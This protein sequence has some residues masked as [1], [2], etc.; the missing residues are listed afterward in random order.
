[1]TQITELWC[2]RCLQMLPIGNFRKRPRR[3]ETG[4]R[5]GRWSYCRQCEIN[6]VKTVPGRRE[7]ANSNTYAS[8]RRLKENNPEEYRRRY[9]KSHLRK[10]HGITIADYDRLFKEQNGHCAICE[11]PP[12]GVSLHVDHDHLTG[13]I[14]GLLCAHCNT[15]IGLL[16]DDQLLLDKAA[17]Y[18]SKHRDL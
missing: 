18:I 1:M 8:R 10:Y 17:K 11:N 12:S 14:R 7:S 2:T 4:K 6:I 5:L 3:P 16:R 9:R 13:R 15:G